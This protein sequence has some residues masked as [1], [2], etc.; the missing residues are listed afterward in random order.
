MT[1][2]KMLA[3]AA[4]GTARTLHARFVQDRISPRRKTLVEFSGRCDT[5][6]P[7][8]ADKRG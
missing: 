5:P 3:A 7:S 6:Y 2:I 1:F 8:P 4:A